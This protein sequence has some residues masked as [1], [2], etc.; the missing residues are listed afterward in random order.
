MTILDTFRTLFGIK[1]D[2]NKLNRA[3]YESFY[4]DGIVTVPIDNPDS[5]LR[6]G[7]AGNADVYSIISKIDGMRRRAKLK[8]YKKLDTAE[9]EEVEDHPLLTFLQKVNPEMFTDDFIS[10]FLIYRL[11][12]GNAFAYY[13]KIDTGLNRGKT[14][15]IHI[16]PSN[17]IEIIS[18]GYLEPVKGYKIES[19]QQRFEKKEIYH[20]KLFNP[21]FGTDR[22]FYGQSPLKAAARILAKQNQAEITELK[23]FENQG[24]PYIMYRDAA[25]EPVFNRMTDTQQR[26][27]E[28]QVKDAGSEK[29]RGLPLILREKYG[30]INLGRNLADL[31]IIESSKDGRIILCNVLGFP[32]VLL[33]LDAATYN[34][35]KE[36]RKAAWTDCIIPNLSAVEN[37]FNQMLIAGVDEYKDLYF[38]YDYS[39][40]EELQEGM[41]IR[42]NWMKQAGWAKNEIRQA[43][44]RYPIQRPIMDEPIFNPGETPANQMEIPG[45]F[46]DY[47]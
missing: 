42:V 31:D 32:P 36:A 30:I 9:H 1:P 40:I 21:L 24:P 45:G 28:K 15:E 34:N 41:E 39:E 22:T 33:G 5:Y 38:A 35:M 13:P 10:G 20:S 6:Q 46:G 26:E 29:K 7:Y 17:D 11:V 27:I 25:G 14:G 23:Q 44:G 2:K 16:M 12:T 3:L 37:A 19:S 18:G 43:T 8:L 4:F 47:E